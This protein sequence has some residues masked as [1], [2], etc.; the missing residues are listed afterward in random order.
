MALF[1]GHY[2]KKRWAVILPLGGMLASDYFLGFYEWQVM[3][4]VY[5]SIA[6]AFV[7]G[8]YLQKRLKWWSLVFASLTSSIVFFVITNFAVWAF[9]NWYPHTWQG[10]AND[11]TL[12]LPFFRNSLLGDLMYSG[13]FFGAYELILLW[14]NKM[15]KFKNA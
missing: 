11:F 12:A 9:T 8:W 4:S 2:V 13:L 7:I 5:A 10:L 14:L 1:A 6:L 15:L 3:T